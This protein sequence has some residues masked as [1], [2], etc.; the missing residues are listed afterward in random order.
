MTDIY[1]SWS[2]LLLPIASYF[3]AKKMYPKNLCTIMGTSIGLVISPSGIGLYYAAYM[4]PFIGII[5]IAFFGL[6]SM[7]H[8]AAGLGIAEYLNLAKKC[9]SGLNLWV[10][11]INCIIWGSFYGG[12]GFIIDRLR[13]KKNKDQEKPQQQ[14]PL[15]RE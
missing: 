5:L 15:D 7:P 12:V 11:L 4:M 10:E 8:G 14:A 13:N 2:T 9:S 3:I 6:V 1:I